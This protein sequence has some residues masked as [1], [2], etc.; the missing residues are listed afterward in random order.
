MEDFGRG[1][2]P[3]YEEVTKKRVRGMK[4]GSM[5]QN[6]SFNAS[7]QKSEEQATSDD[8]YKQSDTQ[9]GN[10]DTNPFRQSNQ[11]MQ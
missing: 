7:V 4:Y 3:P 8:E 5:E 10:R 9:G 1:P 2:P 6:G 11:F